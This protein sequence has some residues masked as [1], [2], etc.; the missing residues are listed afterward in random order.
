M[1]ELEQEGC[2]I[3]IPCQDA[4]NPQILRTD[5][6]AEVL[7]LRSLGVRR[8]LFRVWSDMTKP[9]GHADAIRPNEVLGQ[10]VVGVAVEALGIPSRGG[11]LI[12]GGVG[13]EPQPDDPRGIAIIGPGGY[14][15]AARADRD[16]RIFLCV[17]ERV[18]RAIGIADVEP[19]P[20][21]IPVRSGGLS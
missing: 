17:F 8:R 18:A 11:G 16:T 21:A 3:G 7:P 19:E 2:R 20:I 5:G 14:V 6:A 13:E 15:P 10:V 12:E 4:V 1:Q 9:A